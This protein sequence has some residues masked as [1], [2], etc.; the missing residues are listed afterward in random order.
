[1]STGSLT[2]VHDKSF[3]AYTNTFP[4]LFVLVD[5]LTAKENSAVQLY[6]GISVPVGTCCTS[7]CSVL[8]TLFAKGVDDLLIGLAMPAAD[9]QLTDADMVVRGF[10]VPRSLLR[11]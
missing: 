7:T 4:S 10:T 1:V 6:D 8:P 9:S 2:H 5:F 3:S 11:L